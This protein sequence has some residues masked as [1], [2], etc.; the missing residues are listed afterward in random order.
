MKLEFDPPQSDLREVQGWLTQE[1]ADSGESFICNWNIVEEASAGDRCAVAKMDRRAVAFI[2]WSTPRKTSEILIMAVEPNLRRQ[3]FGAHLVDEFCS[4]FSNQLGVLAL[5]LECAPIS[6]EPFWRR[7]G[8]ID[9]PA[10][11][12]EFKRSGIHLFKPLIDRVPR[13][14]STNPSGLLELWH[15]MPHEVTSGRQADVEVLLPLDESGKSTHPFVIPA[16]SDW[17]ARFSRKG[18][19][20]LESKVKYL[21]SNECRE[22]GFLVGNL[23]LSRVARKGML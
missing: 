2:V 9:Y 18:E 16:C 13:G 14:S 21:F 6:S 7:Q 4:H 8:F 17:Q 23:D 15:G 1:Q 12:S 11:H 20:V 5:T 22:R 10:N 19:P 3:G